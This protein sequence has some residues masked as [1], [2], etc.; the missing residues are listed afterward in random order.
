MGLPEVDGLR[1]CMPLD[2]L[3]TDQKV[4]NENFDVL[5]ECPAD[6]K[7]TYFKYQKFFDAVI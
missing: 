2:I 3:T 7:R 4:L 6:C 5:S 1:P